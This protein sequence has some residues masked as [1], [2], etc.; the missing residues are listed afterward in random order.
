MKELARIGEVN[1]TFNLKELDVVLHE[2]ALGYR[3]LCL[4]KLGEISIQTAHIDQYE[5]EAEKELVRA[6]EAD[7]NG[8]PEFAKLHRAK[9]NTLRANACYSR[10]RAKQASMEI[11][12]IVAR[13][14]S[15]G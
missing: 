11:D 2:K 3:R 5:A 12:Y 4:D 14:L 7:E 15:D 13:G 8:K 9:A 6:K 1:K 10:E